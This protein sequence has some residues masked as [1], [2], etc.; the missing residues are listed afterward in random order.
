MWFG[1]GIRRRA[2]TLV[3][4]RC[5]RCSRKSAASSDATA[6]LYA[7]PGAGAGVETATQPARVRDDLARPAQPRRD[8]HWRSRRSSAGCSRCSTSPPRAK[9]RPRAAATA[10]ERSRRPDADSSSRRDTRCFSPSCASCHGL[11]RRASPAARRACTAS[12]RWRRLLPG[13]GTDAAR[14]ATRSSRCARDRPSPQRQIQALIAYVASFGG[15]A[16]PTVDPGRARSRRD[17]SCSRSNCAGCH[18]IQARGGI[19]TGRCPVA[20]TATPRQIAEAIRIGPYAMPRFG[21][22]RAL[23]RARSTRSPATCRA[24][25]HPDDPGGWGIGRIGPI[26]EGMVAWLLA[27]AALLLIARLLGERTP[28]Q[29]RRPV[30]DPQRV[31]AMRAP[32]RLEAIVAPAR[33]LALR[34]AAQQPPQRRPS[35]IPSERRTGAPAWA[36]RLG[37]RRCWG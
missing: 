30:S 10:R 20:D 21:A 7:D 19:V 3:A 12:A 28:A 11:R 26:T 27:V 29:R 36:E 32:A 1:G 25:N 35:R 16:I 9:R 4:R 33:R 34:S 8:A 2:L 18:T 24:R 31:A 23:E 17:S 22:G 13:D 37:R 14:H 5:R 15:P 6:T